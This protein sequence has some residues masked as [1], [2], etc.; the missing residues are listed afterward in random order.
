MRVLLGEA[1]P[2]CQPMT[3]NTEG[4]ETVFQA[5]RVQ[6][7]YWKSVKAPPFEPEIC[8]KTT[9]TALLLLTS[10]V[11]ADPAAKH[12]PCTLTLFPQNAY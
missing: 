10:A 5:A 12:L 1:P 4:T 11:V 3:A 7:K 2:N 9:V 8:E 6:S